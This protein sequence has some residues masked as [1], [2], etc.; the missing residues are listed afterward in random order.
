MRLLAGVPIW[1]LLL[2]IVW[3][4]VAIAVGV[5]TANAG[6]RNALAEAGE[7]A[8]ADILAVRMEIAAARVEFHKEIA[9][10]GVDLGNELKGARRETQR[11]L[12]ETLLEVRGLRTQV[13]RMTVA[14]EDRQ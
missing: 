2:W 7:Q 5:A 10:L 13:D 6:T 3:A 12:N 14:N 9:Q 4:L 8:Q 1:L 11:Q